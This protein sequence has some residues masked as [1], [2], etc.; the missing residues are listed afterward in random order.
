MLQRSILRFVGGI[1]RA[2]GN[3]HV[4]SRARRA[5]H[6][7]LFPSRTSRP[8]PPTLRGPLPSSLSSPLA[9]PPCPVRGCSADIGVAF[10]MLRFAPGSPE[11]ARF[12]GVALPALVFP[13][14]NRSF[15]SFHADFSSASCESATGSIFVASHVFKYFRLQER[16]VS[17]DTRC[18]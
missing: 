9:F 3:A 17:V 5:R 12:R 15:L 18:S 11:V 14:A 4:R 8:P 6:C 10:G 7:S 13:M 16:H 1:G 2:N